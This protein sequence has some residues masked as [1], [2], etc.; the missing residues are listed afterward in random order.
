MY[1]KFSDFG[2]SENVLSALNSMGYKEPSPIQKIVI[3]P[4]LKGSDVIGVAQ[5]GTGKTAA[6]G[7][8]LVEKCIKGRKKCP[9]A[10][11]LVP[12]RELAVQVA[13]ELKKIG[14]KK[15][16]NAI[17][18]YGGQSI[19]GQIQSL[20]R[21]VDIVV[22]TPGRVIDHIERRTLLLNETRSVVLDEADEMLNMGFIGDMEKILKSIPE[23][24]HTMLFSATMPDAIVRMSAKYMKKP[25]KIFADAGKTVVDKTEQVFYE[26]R[27]NEKN[28]VL[29]ALLDVENPFLALVFCHTKR[30]VEKVCRNLQQKGYKAGAIHG[31]FSQAS[32]DEVMRK[33]RSGNLAIL[34]A[35]DVAARG[36]DITNI[37]HVINYSVPD[38]PERYVHRI[39]RTGRAGKS[40]KAI[41]LVTPREKRQLKL[42]EKAARTKISRESLPSGNDARKARESKIGTE[43]ESVILKGKHSGYAAIVKT[44][45]LRFSSGDIAAAALHLF[46]EKV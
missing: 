36:L 12:T 33:F 11:V 37:S 25:Q 3:G 14:A 20:K 28:E 9:Y 18:V 41:T 40:G 46:A 39:G 38:Y 10:I 35:T 13:G 21:G 43:L 19:S 17:A 45:S 34:V 42:I 8:P 32:R 44:L 29:T 31:D 15:G 22:G 2:L 5:T 27:E 30:E 16:I 24:R 6:F 1:E 4:L 26:V 7:I 23:E